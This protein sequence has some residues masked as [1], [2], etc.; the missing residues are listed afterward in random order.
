MSFS[1]GVFSI[2]STG[3]PVVT[4]T[5]ISSSVFNALTADLATGLSTTMLK[6]GTQIMTANV[7]MAGFRFTGLGAGAA[8]GDSVRRSQ[9]GH[10]LLY[11]TSFS[12]TVSAFSITSVLGASYQQ[13]LVKLSQL[14][15]D[16]SGTTLYCRSSTDNGATYYENSDYQ[17]MLYAAGA[18]ISAGALLSQIVGTGSVSGMAMTC[19]LYTSTTN[20]ICNVDVLIDN[21]SSTTRTKMFRVNGMAYN[22]NLNPTPLMGA[23]NNVSTVSAISAIKFYGTGGQI[24]AANIAVYGIN[25]VS[26][27]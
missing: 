25:F 17:T 5:T 22:S 3:Q 13:Y 19:P 1:G 20:Q 16:T 14:V 27:P 11:A 4:G 10:V 24:A 15:A 21:P 7:P 6:D 23:G 18:T 8:N 9:V 26:P 12:A 2:N